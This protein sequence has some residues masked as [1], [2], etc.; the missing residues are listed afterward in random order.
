MVKL[1]NISNIS[2]LLYTLAL[3]SNLAHRYGCVIVHRNKVIATGFNRYK[4]KLYI[5]GCSLL[6][7]QSLHYPR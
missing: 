4:A 7:T 2:E 5:S 6:R 1:A 3:K